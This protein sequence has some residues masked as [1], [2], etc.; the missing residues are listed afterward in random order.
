[1]PCR[2]DGPLKVKYIDDSEIALSSLLH[3]NESRNKHTKRKHNVSM[4]KTD[5]SVHYALRNLSCR[6]LAALYICYLVACSLV[7]QSFVSW[8]D[9]LASLGGMRTER[10]LDSPG[11]ESSS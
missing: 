2:D 6:G 10:E 4:S 11:A 9:W 5:I 1:M 3:T 7:D 8:T